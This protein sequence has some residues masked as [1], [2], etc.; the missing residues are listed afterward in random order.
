MTW[1]DVFVVVWAIV[2]V[3]GLAWVLWEVVGLARARRRNGQK[4]GA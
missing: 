1:L 2:L 4:G 3:A